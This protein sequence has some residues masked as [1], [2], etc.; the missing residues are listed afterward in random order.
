MV[1]CFRCSPVAKA[2]LDALLDSGAFADY[3]EVISAA[4]ENFAVLHEEVQSRGSI[5]LDAES[6]SKGL[7]SIVSASQRTSGS[8]PHRSGKA[9][10]PKT[11]PELFTM[12][13]LSVEAPSGLAPL[14]G[15]VFFHGQP[16]SIDRWVF[17]QYSRLLPVKVSCRALAR[18]CPCPANGF[19]LDKVASRIAQEAEMLG[20]YLAERDQEEGLIRD[21]ASAIGFPS[22]ENKADRSRLRYANQFVGAIGKQGT[23]TGLLI[24]LKLINLAKNGKKGICLTRP[25][26]EFAVLENPVLDGSSADGKFTP[27]E[28]KFLLQHIQKHVP[29]EDFAFR[30]LLAAINDGHDT[31]DKLDEVCRR[32]VPEQRRD[33]ISKAVITTQRAGVVA[34][35]I[36]LGLVSRRRDGVRVSY[37][38]AGPAHHYVDTAP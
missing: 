16:I 14:P 36:D 10:Q 11:V 20:K 30:T 28:V 15:D 6:G 24:D 12:G 25:G 31:P 35:M 18:M 21:Q 9:N 13:N 3:S 4:I 23:L 33:E 8:L 17:G 5:V 29:V 38:I 26:W 34:R 22:S 19:E 7:E 27:V 37:V 32:Y 1:I 2:K